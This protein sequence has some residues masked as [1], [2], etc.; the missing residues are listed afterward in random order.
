MLH[1]A[2]SPAVSPANSL[3]THFSHL[4]RLRFRLA[5]NDVAPSHGAAD[6]SSEPRRSP[7][8]SSDDGLLG[9]HRAYW[10]LLL[11]SVVG[12][13]TFLSLCERADARTRTIVGVGVGAAAPTGDDDDTGVEVDAEIGR[14]WEIPLLA[15]AGELGGSYAGFS[16]LDVYR[17]VVG[18][19]LSVGAIFQPSVFGHVGIGRAVFEDGVV[20]ERDDHTG[21]TYDVG[22]GLDFTLLPLLDIGV[23]G[24]YVSLPSP[25]PTVDWIRLG[26]HVR[27][28]F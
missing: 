11:A 3:P 1:G 8:A 15:L 17:G 23:Q 18:A 24:A 4:T 28:V 26:G 19:R 20:F 16:G 13:A 2:R 25:N 27:L 7:H 9:R 14:R 6:H 5:S 10:Q 12:L 21:F 22:A